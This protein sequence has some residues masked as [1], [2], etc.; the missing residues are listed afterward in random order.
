MKAKRK[1]AEATEQAYR[2]LNPLSIFLSM[3]A[4]DMAEAANYGKDNDMTLEESRA[5]T[6]ELME[7]IQ[8]AFR[9]IDQHMADLGKAND[10]IDANLAYAELLL[11]SFNITKH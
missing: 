4:T 10:R 7:K 8:K 11:D 5:K 6:D 9:E 3:I 1:L 2:E